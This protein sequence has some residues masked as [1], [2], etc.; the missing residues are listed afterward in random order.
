[1][2]DTYKRSIELTDSASARI[3][4]VLE[5]SDSSKFRVF[6]TGEVARASNMVLSL[7]R[8]RH[9]MMML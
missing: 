3:M 7:I 9:L 1:M 4:S 8:T 6:V 2:E 5:D